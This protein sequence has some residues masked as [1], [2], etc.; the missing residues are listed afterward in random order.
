MSRFSKFIETESRFEFTRDLGEGGGNSYCLMSFPVWEDK[1][2]WKI[3][4]K[5]PNMWKLNYTLP[6]SP[7][8]KKKSQGKLKEI[9]LNGNNT[10]HSKFCGLKG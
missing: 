8:V 10:R 9:E 2:F 1:K 7:R 5:F 3:A 6:N 4:G